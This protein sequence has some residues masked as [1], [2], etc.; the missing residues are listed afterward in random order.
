[1]RKKSDANIAKTP[2]SRIDTIIR[3]NRTAKRK[4]AEKSVKKPV[5]R[6]GAMK[7]PIISKVKRMS[8]VFKS[9]E[10]NILVIQ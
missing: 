10:K 6:S 3:N 9:G 7:I 4:I 1:M 2:F 5:K 8:N